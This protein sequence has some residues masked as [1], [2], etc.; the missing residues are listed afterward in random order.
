MFT[1]HVPKALGGEK[2]HFAPTWI[3]SKIDRFRDTDT[4]LKAFQCYFEVKHSQYYITLHRYFY[5][6][7]SA[8]I[9]LAKCCIFNLRD[10]HD[11]S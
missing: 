5:T 1:K 4:L 7:I 3:F 11:L 10:Y 9:W 8:G 6:V 2:P